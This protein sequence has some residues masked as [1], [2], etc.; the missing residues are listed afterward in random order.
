[1]TDEESRTLFRAGRLPKTDKQYSW[2]QLEEKYENLLKKYLKVKSVD[3]MFNLRTS[4]ATC[5]SKPWAVVVFRP[6]VSVYFSRRLAIKKILLPPANYCPF[7]WPIVFFECGETE[8]TVLGTMPWNYRRSFDPEER[9]LRASRSFQVMQ[10]MDALENFEFGKKNNAGTFQGRRN[11][12]K[13]QVVET[14]PELYNF[15][16]AIFHFDFDPCPLHPKYN[17]MCTP[18]GRM[19]YVNPPFIFSDAFIFRAIEMAR[20][21]DA[22]SVVLCPANLRA[23]WYTEL[24]DTG[25][26]RAVVFLRSGVRFSGYTNP[27]NL[28][29]NLLLISKNEGKSMPPVVWFL[30][31]APTRKRTKMTVVDDSPLPLHIIGWS[32]S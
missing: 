3:L 15:L 19:N 30:D 9:M 4:V 25:F 21:H 26:L 23:R 6:N 13:N 31:T 1:M 18:W 10:N 14:P 17:A 27:C 5:D 11:G 8:H 7:P 20:T 24:V 29:L 32:S 22:K 12:I 28:P 2:F 16:D